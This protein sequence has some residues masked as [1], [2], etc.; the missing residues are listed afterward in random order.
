MTA[1]HAPA[2]PHT[3]RPEPAHPHPPPAAAS[4]PDRAAGVAMS[5]GRR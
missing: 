1:R 4:R 2:R 3:T 5:R